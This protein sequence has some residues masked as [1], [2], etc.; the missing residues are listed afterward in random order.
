MHDCPV[1]GEAC[2]CDGEDVYYEFAPNSCNHCPEEEETS[3]DLCPRCNGS[4]KVIS[5]K[6]GEVIC[7][8]ICGGKGEIRE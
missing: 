6:S 2:D 4:G 8:A 5:S 7:C 3:I 1:C